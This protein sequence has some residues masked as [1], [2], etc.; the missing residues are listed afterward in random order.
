M[1]DGSPSRTALAT[2]AMRAAHQALELGSILLDPLALPLIGDADLAMLEQGI[3]S[4]DMRTAIRLC[5]MARARAAEDALAEAVAQGV[6]QLILLGAGLD[7][8]PY[9]N[10][11]RQLQVF[12]VD[13]PATQTWKIQRLAAANIQVPLT[14]RY[15]AVDFETQQLMQALAA[16]GFDPAKASFVIWM[17]VTFYITEVAMFATLR[18]IAS[19]ATGTEIIFDYLQPVRTMETHVKELRADVAERTAALGE[20]LTTFFERNVLHS[21]LAAEGFSV[22]SD[23]ALTA[24]ARHYM[25]GAEIPPDSGG[26]NV[27]HAKV[28]PAGL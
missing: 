7:S 26:A 5:V 20:Q 12:E 10:P 16:A 15:V 27:L 3:A 23:R 13:H 2:A 6:D 19:L 4:P 11:H 9:R 17:G 1:I 25:P 14:V 18:D 28:L 8:F 21:K 22:I 24:L